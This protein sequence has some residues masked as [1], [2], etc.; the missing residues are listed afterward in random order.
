MRRIMLLALLALVLPT[1]ALAN[2]ISSTATTIT[3]PFSCPSSATC[4]IL[5]G[6]PN[7]MTIFQPFSLLLL[8]TT[9]GSSIKISGITLSPNP[10]GP[11]T[12]SCS[13]TGGLLAVMQAGVTKDFGIV[14]GAFKLG[15]AN[16]TATGFHALLANGGSL[17]LTAFSWNGS[18]HIHSSGSATVHEPTTVIPEPGTLG[19]LGTGLLGLAGMTRRKRKLGT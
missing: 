6:H 4:R 14:S 2:S 15:P 16:R 1:A 7:F 17:A 10:C 9:A 13:F 3:I 5:S 19:L 18:G 8:G 12:A 11:A